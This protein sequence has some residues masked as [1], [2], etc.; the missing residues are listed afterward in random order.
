MPFSAFWRNGELWLLACMLLV[1]GALGCGRSESY[2]SQPITLLCPWSAGG[3]TDRVSRQ[4]AAQLEGALGVPVNVIN[5][6]GG[7][8]VTG[9]TRGAQARNDGYTLT[10][11]TVELNMLHWRGLTSVTYKDFHPL[12]LLNRDSAAL[13]VRADSSIASLDQLRDEI[14]Q[15]PGKLKASGTA[16]GG[17]WHVAMAGWLDQQGVDPT[18]ATWISINGSGPSIQ[19]LN[20]GG[21]DFI[22]CSLPEVDAL[23]ASGDVRCLGVMSDERVGGFEQVPTFKEQGHDWS[24]AG[25]RG[26][27]APIGIPADRLERLEAAI[28]ELAHSE[29]L[30]DFMSQA[31]FNLSLEG[32]E[33]FAQ[34]LS[35]QDLIFKKVLTGPAFTTIKGEQFGAM[36]FPL[37]ILTLLV[38]LL[39]V[40]I[41]KS[42][43]SQKSRRP[44]PLV[45]PKLFGVI[46]ICV[47][48]WLVSETV[49][50][51]LGAILL[52]IAVGLMVSPREQRLGNMKL[53]VPFAFLFSVL[54]YQGFAIWLS[55]PLPRG[56]WGW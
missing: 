37:M 29:E 34:T 50:F 14:A 16:F 43:V 30:R 53:T 20:A 10:M 12:H 11:V 13:F 35:R 1:I 15:R 8:G 32:S 42:F 51:L 38:G 45:W 18:A 56:W 47:F 2:P 25:W 17:I 44:E 40:L 27:A 39:A 55:V 22:C 24:I 41:W 5:A 33:Q 6:T 21:V 19:E 49:G 3:G 9:H 28:G 26:L 48:Y 23:L 46:T 31:G 54:V 4:V 52:I 36:L 7:S